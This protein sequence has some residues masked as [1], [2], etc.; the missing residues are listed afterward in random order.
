MG[1]EKLARGSTPEESHFKNSFGRGWDSAYCKKVKV[2]FSLF[3]FNFC[4]V[5]CCNTSQLLLLTGSRLLKLLKTTIC[6]S[7]RIF[8]YLLLFNFLLL[9]KNNSN[10]IILKSVNVFYTSVGSTGMAVTN[11]TSARCW[12]KIFAVARFKFLCD[13]LLQLLP[14]LGMEKMR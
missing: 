6:I 13:L 8:V 4:C 10:I 3:T 14:G 2:K 7:T 12:H 11:I 1:G 5:N 9:Q